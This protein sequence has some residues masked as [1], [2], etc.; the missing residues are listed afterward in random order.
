MK[1]RCKYCRKSLGGETSNGTSHLRSHIKTCIQK[2]I[3]DGSQKILGPNYKP[4]G[5]PQLSASQYNYEVSRKELCSMILVHEYP[6][7]LVDHVGFKRFCCSLQPQFAVPSRNTVKKDILSLY[8]VERGKYHTI[9]DGNLGRVSITTDLWT[10]RNQKRGYMA[11]TGHFIDNS[12]KL[13]NIMMRFMYVPAPHTSERL[14][15][16]L[17][18]CL[19][20]WN[21]DG[22][23]SSITLDKCTTNDSMIF[24]MRTKLLSSDLLLDG[25]LVHMRCS[26]HILNLI[27]RDGLDAIKD[28]IN[29]IR[30]SVVYW[31]S[32]PKRVQTFF[33]VA[34]QLKLS[35]EKKLVL[36]CPTRWNSTYHMLSVAIPYKDVFFRLSLRDSHYTSVPSSEQWEFASTVIGKLEIFSEI[37]E[38]FSGSKYPTANL[39][40]P[41]IC[42]LRIKLNEW[43]LDPN[44]VIF[45]MASQMSLKFDKYW[46][47]IHLVLAVSVVLDPRYKLHVIEYYAGKFGNTET[48]LV[49]ENIKQM[50]C[51]LIRDYQTKAENKSGSESGT[52]SSGYGT[53]SATEL[54]FELF[55]SQR[56]KSKT[57]LITTELDM[58]LAEDIIPR[59]AEFDL[60]L[61]WKLNGLKYPTLQSI[62]RD[63][64][65]IP[66]TS[67]P[68]ES[69]FSS[70]GRLLDPHRSRLHYS[71]VEAMMCTRSWIMEDMQ[72]GKMQLNLSTLLVYV[73][74]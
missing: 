20:D 45:G 73:L 31:N 8:G 10:A 52:S 3:H 24:Y 60:L 58:Y 4:S 70:G 72:R 19:L 49:A 9:I 7:S 67:V 2:R 30:E 21:I 50:I 44:P 55:V 27:V 13:R 57:S 54:D 66:I 53:A 46:D 23:L 35:F 71:T 48:G 11:I 32:T 40:F 25:K 37:T 14:A 74:E 17:F 22:K 42:D 16:R 43:G 47:D 68:S 33:E 38:L 26:A 6:L 65:A 64:L 63:F 5:N 28:A 12:W 18:D 69:A 59:T 15:D 29:L 39:F 51:G 36:D 41:K 1:A 56:K 34:K 61:W 62:A